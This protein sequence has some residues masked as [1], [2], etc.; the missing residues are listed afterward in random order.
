MIAG[1]KSP[2]EVAEHYSVTIH[3]LCSNP[4]SYPTPE[5]IWAVYLTVI[6]PDGVKYIREDAA[7]GPPND[8]H[9]V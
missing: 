8:A 7:C 5:L 2:C 9:E 3:E 1:E 4:P 6:T